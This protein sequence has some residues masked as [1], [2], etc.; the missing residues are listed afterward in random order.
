MTDPSR[1]G[2]LGAGLALAPLAASAGESA[3]VSP[4]GGGGLE[5]PPSGEG[6]AADDGAY[7]SRIAGLYDV[8]RE[9]IQLENGNWGVMPRPVAAANARY[10]DSVN[11]RSS[12]YGRREYV[13]DWTRVRAKAA[14]SLGVSPDEI[15]LTRGATEA[16]QALIGGYNRLRPGDGVLF[17]DLDYDSMQW[18][19]GWLKA[20][21]GVD[22]LSIALPE[23]A[24]RQGLIDAYAAALEAHP[25][26]RLI[27]VTHVS[28]RTGLVL[29]VAEIVALARARGVDAIVD[30]AHAWGQ[31]DFRLPD[32]GADFV[33]LNGHKWIGAPIG[34]GVLYVRQGRLDAIDPFMG[35]QEF[36]E[37]TVLS[38]THS[39]TMSYATVLAF[40]DAIDLHER[41]T[42][43]AKRRRLRYLRDRWAEAV[44]GHGRIEVLTPA[45]PALT[46]ALTSFRLKGQGS[47]QQNRA[48]AKALLDRFNIFTVARDG[49]AA[50]SCVRVTPALFTTEAEVDQLVQALKVLGA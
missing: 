29:P 26:V 32:L 15:A 17:A 27:L 3:P 7:W 9:V 34:V 38:R 20:R 28:H 8:S 5:L 13:A 35:S 4:A 46:S 44:R 48:L 37:D 36:H 45:D 30:S 19:M 10:L 41:I 1:R 31:L 50:G 16:L 49:V 18:A 2:L 33:G 47:P 22:V 6:V 12:F 23:P 43:G 11:R 21:R 24:T 14:A 25:A 39:G 42:A 40:G